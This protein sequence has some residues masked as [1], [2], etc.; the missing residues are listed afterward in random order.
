M[1]V[2]Q[3]HVPI[4]VL[5]ENG[6]G[7]Q[8]ASLEHT[9][10]E[11]YEWSPKVYRDLNAQPLYR[12]IGRYI[13]PHT[14]DTL[15]TR[16][17]P[18]KAGASPAQPP[19]GRQVA[20]EPTSRPATPGSRPGS[21]EAEASSGLGL[22]GAVSGA[23]ADMRL[24][25]DKLPEFM[26]A[27]Y[28]T[29]ISSRKRWREREIQVLLRDA[30]EHDMVAWALRRAASEPKGWRIEAS[31]TLD[32][33]K[34]RNAAKGFELVQEEERLKA[35]HWA[36]LPH[37]GALK[38]TWTDITLWAVL[39]GTKYTELAQ[40]AWAKTEEPMRTAIWAA[41]LAHA[42]SLDTDLNQSKRDEW[43]EAAATY[44]AWAYGVLD[45]CDDTEEAMRQLTFA[46]ARHGH[47]S[48]LDHAT[49]VDAH[50]RPCRLF[51]SH[52]HCEMLAL[53]YFTGDCPGSQTCIVDPRWWR[54]LL[55]LM[56]LG[57]LPFAHVRSLRRN[58][59]GEK[60]DAFSGHRRHDDHHGADESDEE[61]DAKAHVARAA[62]GASSGAGSLAQ[63]ASRLATSALGRGY[64]LQ[65]FL[66]I[67][68]VRAPAPAARP[69]LPTCLTPTASPLSASPRAPWPER[70]GPSVSPSSPL[71]RRVSRSSPRL[72]PTP[73]PLSS[74]ATSSS[75]R[76][77]RSRS[78]TL[79][80]W[81]STCAAGHGRRPA[82]CTMRVLLART[83]STRGRWSA[84]RG[85]CSRLWRRSSSSW[86]RPAAL[87]IIGRVCTTRSTSSRTYPSWSPAASRRHS[88]SP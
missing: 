4:R 37:A 65:H 53:R 10:G 70:R 84:G 35:K 13:A 48:V 62:A 42:N 8:P 56:F 43:K 74:S 34:E 78:C 57:L 76:T 2:T 40:C 88:R 26:Q 21:P 83:P 46:T 29:W 6:K 68:C 27:W 87:P 71:L 75:S 85:R 28:D 19:R 67:P 61:E 81:R 69:A 47:L 41:H 45:E 9:W 17:A 31:D 33:I 82:G 60:R 14:M 24:F 58:A 32:E 80:T 30:T 3:Q 39:S 7:V 59:D 49:E 18:A 25:T 73:F 77:T 12:R 63:S 20:P 51:V 22:S 38:T 86:P 23:D 11:L 44:E 66:A 50:A 15:L 54:T 36:Q 64:K 55:H 16:K 72:E 1:Q 5:M 52:P 79:C